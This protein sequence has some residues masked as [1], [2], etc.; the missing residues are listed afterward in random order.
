M[1]IDELNLSPKGTEQVLTARVRY[2]DIDRPATTVS[3]A[4]DAEFAALLAP[5][6][7][8]I[9]L[10]C[11]PA[12]LFHA[13]K[14]I[15]IEG[16]ICPYLLDNV[17]AA[18]RM[19]KMWW[20]DTHPVP[21]LEARNRRS[22]PQARRA[23]V[24][25]CFL[26]GGVDSMANAL[27]N[28]RIFEARHPMRNRYGILVHGLDIGDP[29]R[30]DA[31]GLYD[32]SLSRLGRFCDDID[33]RLIALRTDFRDIEPDWVFYETRHFAALLSGLAHALTGEIDRCSIALDNAV[34][35]QIPWASHPRLNRCF[36]SS[37]LTFVSELEAFSRLDKVKIIASNDAAL[38]ALRVCYHTDKVPE[39]HINCGRCE[40]C[41]R[42]K[43]E[44][45]VAGALSDRA[46]F[47][48]TVIPR[49]TVMLIEPR[50]ALFREFY[51]ELVEPL[52]EAG[53]PDLADALRI[54]LGQGSPLPRLAIRAKKRYWEVRRRLREIGR[55]PQGAAPDSVE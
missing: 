50:A 39:G 21:A 22:S 15:R 40:K 44:L 19:Q 16:D 6:Y 27:R 4:V 1:I 55:R 26:S 33:L 12:A 43:M 20:K 8:A 17:A 28:A 23:N 47:P 54:G 13:E 3:I 2:E 9:L 29:N 34:E 10:G 37:F 11:F 38:H 5:R 32:E 49:E 25:A 18:L 36:S 42:T 46:A 7:E 14:R 52:T 30:T 51:E 35:H 41:L 24:A 48:D 45:L 53:R 31:A